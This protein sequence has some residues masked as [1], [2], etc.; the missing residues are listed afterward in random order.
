MVTDLG[1]DVHEVNVPYVTSQG[2]GSQST[3]SQAHAGRPGGR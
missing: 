3:A 1:E 2:A